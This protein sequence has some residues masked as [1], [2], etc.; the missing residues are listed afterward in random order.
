M[1][2]SIRWVD[3]HGGSVGARTDGSGDRYHIT[4]YI[5]HAKL[6]IVADEPLLLLDEF[7]S[8][9]AAKQFAE[10]YASGSGS[11]YAVAAVMA[12]N[13]T[14]EFHIV[15]HVVG[16]G[17]EPAFPQRFGDRQTAEQWLQHKL[18]LEQLTANAAP[19]AAAG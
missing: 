13:G 18:A 19:A 12:A 9:V 17:I 7:P 15:K 8:V 16:G 14:A 2:G 11:K 6:T 5:T 3:H 1:S 10:F 4:K